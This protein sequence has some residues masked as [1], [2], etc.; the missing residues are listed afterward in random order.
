MDE[1][2]ALTSRMLNA[3]G[4]PTAFG[5]YVVDSLMTS[6]GGFGLLYLGHHRS[7]APRVTIRVYPLLGPDAH[8]EV[9]QDWSAP[10]RR[11]AGLEIPR[12]A[13]VRAYGT[14][15][16]SLYVVT[17]LP[18]GPELGASLVHHRPTW[19]DA[20]R[21]VARTALT[22]EC[23][24]WSGIVHGD[25]KP[26]NI[27]LRKDMWPVLS[28]PEP[29]ILKTTLPGTPAY[30]AP[31]R[32]EGKQVDGR[33]DIY[34]LGVILYEMLCGRPPFADRNVFERLRRVREEEPVP[35]RQLVPKIPPRLE[36]IC[37][38]AMAKRVTDR[39][40]TASDLRRDIC[41][42]LRAEGKQV[43]DL[44]LTLGLPTLGHSP[45]A[46]SMKSPVGVWRLPADREVGEPLSP[47]AHTWRSANRGVGWKAM[48][49]VAALIALGLAAV[50][51]LFFFLR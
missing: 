32:F 44:E 50:L 22:L 2:E 1:S 8:G 33:A 42:W 47:G 16:E 21:I 12:L 14:E 20:A 4:Y 48:A 5:D 41:E 6:R 10:I 35:P 13:T 19:H 38:K 39:Y 23:L 25:V 27:T 51:S 28:A 24:H 31:E 37:L 7:G 26:A 18:E 34:S 15:Q 36:A 11:L 9:E 29:P 45:E 43:G 49:T 40:T 46:A 17:D 30:M 3:P